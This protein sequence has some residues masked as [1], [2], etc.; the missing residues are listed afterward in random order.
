ME[1]HRLLFELSH[2]LRFG[3][4][5][6]LAREPRRLTD[7]A[8]QVDANPPEVSRHLN[9]LGEAGIVQRNP[10]GTYS[11]APTGHIVM[12]CLPSLEFLA[13]HSEFFQKHDLSLLPAH[14]VSRLGD[15]KNGDLREG[16][17]NNMD[18]VRRILER[19]D[20]WCRI[21]TAEALVTAPWG[22]LS[23]LERGVD[24]R[25]LV[26]EAFRF[27]EHKQA[28]Q[29]QPTP[30]MEH[31]HAV[32]RRVPQIPAALAA[33]EK[34]AIVAF[35]GLDGNLD[36][37]AGFYSKDE[38]FGGWC[39]DLV[40]YLWKRGKPWVGSFLQSRGQRPPT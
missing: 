9:R 14:F 10:E 31:I 38:V 23:D 4:I 29:E 35:L 40:D 30:V 32:I 24:Y 34:E 22:L 1:T 21:L 19:A 25:I 6:V 39:S 8:E 15:L 37:T 11:L 26:N 2:P 36:Y 17:F 27:P 7:I 18:L 12:K 20:D 16:A 3:M 33:T 5:H 28:V 13:S